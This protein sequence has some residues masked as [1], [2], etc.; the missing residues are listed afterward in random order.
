IRE[1]WPRT[2]APSNRQGEITDAVNWSPG[3]LSS[4]LIG[5]S[6]RRSIRVPAGADPRGYVWAIPIEGT[7]INAQANTAMCLHRKS[8]T[9]GTSFNCGTYKQAITVPP[10]RKLNFGNKGGFSPKC[11]ELGDLRLHG[12]TVHQYTITLMLAARGFRSANCK[13]RRVAN[14]W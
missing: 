8:F 9:V 1:I 2:V 14:G 11:P 4:V 6:S 7:I 5:V 12:Q 3:R 13:C 10:A